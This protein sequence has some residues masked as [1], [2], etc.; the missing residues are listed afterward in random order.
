MSFGFGPG[1]I[2]AFITF[3]KKVYDASEETEGSQAQYRRAIKQCD[4]F[5]TVINQ[6]KRVDLSHFP[7]DF[8]QELEEIY[9]NAAEHITLFRK[10][11]IDKYKKSLGT[12][13]K[14]GLFTNAPRKVQWADDAAEDMEELRQSLSSWLSAIQMCIMTNML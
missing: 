10:N 9:A 8:R 2:V 13:T 1:D 14:R 12:G 3:S 6:V 11:T 4:A 7:D 5:A